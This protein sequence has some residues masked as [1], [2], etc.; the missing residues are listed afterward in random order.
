MVE[1]GELEGLAA[2]LRGTHNIFARR[3][4]ILERAVGK[5]SGGF[6]EESKRVNALDLAIR[7]AEAIKAN[8]AGFREFY[9]QTM[10]Q[11]L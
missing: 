8:P 9:R 6:I 5:D 11:E 4:P 2:E 10:K 3:L 1:V 7:I